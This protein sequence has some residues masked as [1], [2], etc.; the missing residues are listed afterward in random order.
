M[1]PHKRTQTYL[2]RLALC[3]SLMTASIALAQ[4]PPAEEPK[5]DSAKPATAE[6]PT[7]A[8]KE[9]KVPTKAEAEAAAKAAEE[10]AAFD[11]NETLVL[12][13]FEV[14]TDKDRGYHAGSTMSGTRMGADLDDIAN[15][16]S[17]VTKQQLLDFAARD[18]NDIFASELG[19]EGTRTFTANFNDGKQDVDSVALNPETANRVRGLGNAN[20][21]VGNF[22]KTNT[23]P[24]DVYNIDAVEISR[25]P[26]SSIFGMGEAS[27]TV[28]LVP[29]AA[30][31]SRDHNKFSFSYSSTDTA[32]ATMDV[33]R[34]LWKNTLAIRINALANNQRYLRKPSY[35]DTR[36]INISST[37]HPFKYTTLRASFERYKENYSRPNSVTPR[38]YMTLWNQMGRSSWNPATNQWSYSAYTNNDTGI[39]YPGGT[40]FMN[41]SNNAGNDV[42]RYMYPPTG[43]ASTVNAPFGPAS[44]PNGGVVGS[45]QQLWMGSI[46]TNRVRPLMMIDNGQVIWAGTEYYT[47]VSGTTT[48]YHDSLQ[49]RVPDNYLVPAE[50]QTST[51]GNLSYVPIKAS[52]DKSFYDYETLNLAGLNYGRKKGDT[53]RV[54]F[55]QF[56]VNTP[57]NVFA[58]QLGLFKERIEDYRR[59]FVG[60][61]G[62][63][64]PLYIQPDVNTHLPD[65]T[66]NPKY[67]AP[68]ISALAPQTYV[69]PID[70]RTHRANVV[71][72]LDLTKEK[73]WLKHLGRTKVLG[74]AEEFYK[75]EA[76]SNLRYQDQIS[77]VYPYFL[78][79]NIRNSND[80]KFVTRYYLGDSVGGNVDYGSK[81]PPI[82]NFITFRRFGSVAGETP[83]WYTLENVP[84]TPQYFAISTVHTE[85]TTRGMILQNYLVKDRVITTWGRRRDTLRTR[86]TRDQDLT[87]TSLIDPI[88]ARDPITGLTTSFDWLDNYD[89]WNITN[90]QTMA[91]QAIG[92]TD[93]KGIVVK[94]TKWLSLRYNQSTSFKPDDF[95][96][97]FQGNPL[98]NNGGESKDYGFSI[99]LFKSKVYL[100][101]T[102]YE[103]FSR[104]SR[105]GS[106]NAVAQRITL[107]D[108][109][110]NPSQDGSKQDLEDWLL[111]Q[112]L[113]SQGLM[114]TTTPD[115]GFA[116]A[117]PAQVEA[118]LLDTHRRMGLTE[119]RILL[120]RT[121]TRAMTADRKSNGYEVSLDINPNQYLS[122]KLNGSQSETIFTNFGKTWQDYKKERMPIW[123]TIRSP[124]DGSLWWTTVQT[125][126][127]PA[128]VWVSNNEAPM[129]V[130]LALEGKPVPQ[131]AKYKA[132]ALARYRLAGIF[133]NT[134]IVKDMTVGG[135]VSWIDKQALGFYA[136]PADNVNGDIRV[137][138]Y[139]ASRP[140]WT[141][142]KFY[143][144]AFATYDF[145]MFKNRIK[146]NVQLNAK[147][148]GE[149]GRL[150]TF[151]RQSG[152]FKVQ[153][154][155]HRSDRVHPQRE[156]RAID[157][158]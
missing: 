109:D 73:S 69:N 81:A 26:N 40:G 106:I 87:S 102:R 137:R 104:N 156:L 118:A 124:Y 72:Q 151:R 92:Y 91:R 27:G 84:V 100:T 99:N 2:R 33:N 19:V 67:G 44:L 39:S 61:G 55:E 31:L 6:K 141:R 38:E 23:I 128:Q 112:V 21:S 41:G 158:Q 101:V 47:T 14:T 68:F 25:G 49:F 50:Y 149:N 82:E 153:L 111:G 108:Y 144:D 152:R 138:E 4:T 11:E 116:S 123:T 115:P 88:S 157:A 37:Y 85:T 96:I 127:T 95:G 143:V 119:E 107:L 131:F 150:Q 78:A 32:R 9:K 145:R 110:I 142:A 45:N 134:P 46:G 70:T 28:N 132:N 105:Q 59:A 77:S 52:K 83:G 48:V 71:Y 121:Y 140:I 74:Y 54:E 120:N 79:S 3:A 113:R 65:G 53:W 136:A 147:S 114:D 98:E 57:M 62:D 24:I 51:Y 13:P 15:P 148:V 5:A 125:G 60:N 1:Q 30:N 93:N 89:D 56:L 35:D 17:V 86:G 133:R 64:V 97:D 10:T 126:S 155:H 154:P 36:R 135:K 94:P 29:S 20:I 66:P 90:R 146:G 122:I 7:A 80:A 12:S 42:S 117:T 58:F 43:T 34:V 8:P 18:I 129:K 75:T 63:G 139:D 16:I 103:T 130:N 76:P 22:G